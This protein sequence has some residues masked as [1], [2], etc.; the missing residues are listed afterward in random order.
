MFPT[1]LWLRKA[2]EVVLKAPSP[3][4]IPL[5]GDERLNR[6]DYFY[7]GLDGIDP[8]GDVLIAGLSSTGVLGRPWRDD[9][10]QNDVV[11]IPIARA[12]RAKSTFVYYL[13]R[14]EFVERDPFRFWLKV[15]TGYYKRVAR[16]EER[17]ESRFNRRQLERKERMDVLQ[18]IVR[19]SMENDER[20]IDPVMITTLLYQRGWIRHPEAEEVL[21]RI[22]A[23]VRVLD[24]EGLVEVVQRDTAYRMRPD[25]VRVLDQYMTDERR[26]AHSQALQRK[27]MI[28]GGFAAVATAIQA[29]ANVKQAWFDK[30]ASETPVVH[31]TGDHAA[32]TPRPSSFAL[33]PMRGDQ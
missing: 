11:D 16:R 10:Y 7:A 21:Q 25:A 33:A 13:R 19:L 29:A 9:R 3:D 1:E 31:S 18:A 27:V 26:H 12:V 15:R 23:L 6:R 17:R 2:I 28:L 5:S 22:R 24:A 4:R 8:E 14:F 30:P 20:T 32:A